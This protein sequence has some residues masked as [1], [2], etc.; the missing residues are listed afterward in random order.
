[1]RRTFTFTNGLAVGLMAL[2]LALPVAAGA[3]PMTP[4]ARDAA[5]AAIAAQKPSDTYVDLRS[6]DT[7]DAAMAAQSESPARTD[8]RSPDTRDAANH[9]RVFT[10]PSDLAP[11][12]DRGP[13]FRWADAGIGA[14]TVLLIVLLAGLT[15]AVHRRQSPTARR[16][17]SG[18]VT[19]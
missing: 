17:R 4:D 6:P 15:V 11:S 18:L 12:S 9:V 13:S 8:F 3:L 19:S 14:A 16:R 5:L 10:L 1:M 7:R 2:G